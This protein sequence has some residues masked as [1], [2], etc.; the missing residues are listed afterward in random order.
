M[1]HR[2]HLIR[3]ASQFPAG[4]EGRQALLARIKM[5]RPLA[6]KDA[7]VM[8]FA[9]DHA[10][11][12]SKFYEMDVVPQ[13]QESRARKTKDQSFRGGGWV[14]MRRWGRLADVTSGRAP[15][16]INDIF[17]SQDQAERAMFKIKAEKLRGKG[18]AVYTDVTRQREYP[19][20]LG[21]AGYG[22]GGQ[23]VCQ[24]IPEL[25][26]FKE[27]VVKMNALLRPIARADNDTAKKLQ[28]WLI[29]MG[30]YLESQLAHCR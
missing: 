29:P 22:W 14:L 15:D 3:L 28:S 20:G 18:S 23:A 17:D 25:Q 27:H 6:L 9:I 7:Q 24:V 13:G 19:I 26:T 11:N 8:L 12:Q 30:E 10:K 4:S 16:S 21:P 1:S 2:K 5:A